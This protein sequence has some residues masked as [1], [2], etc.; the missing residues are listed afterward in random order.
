MYIEEKEV[1]CM[2]QYLDF[3]GKS[4]YWHTMRYSHSSQAG[5]MREEWRHVYGEMTTTQYPYRIHK[6]ERVTRLSPSLPS[7][8][9]V[10]A[11][12]QATFGA[13]EEME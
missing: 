1:I 12:V 5:K 6:Q 4:L 11:T 7:T 2:N 13:D 3:E 10:K 8:P 9:Y